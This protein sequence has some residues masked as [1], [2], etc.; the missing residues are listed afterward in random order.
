[1]KEEI[2]KIL[3]ETLSAY[4]PDNDTYGDLAIAGIVGAAEE[5]SKL[6]PQ[7]VSVGERLPEEGKYV[8]AKHNL[9]T[10]KDGKDPINVNTVIVKLEKG[11]S[12]EERQKMKSGELPDYAYPPLWTEADGYKILKRSSVYIDADEWENNKVPYCWESFGIDKFFGQEITHWMPI[13]EL[14]EGK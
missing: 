14:P 12:K 8:I 1:M 9:G 6:I 3:E 7:W 10:W 11:I 4:D 13:T 2:I 5:I